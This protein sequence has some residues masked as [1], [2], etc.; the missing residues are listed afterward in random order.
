MSEED[1]F[2]YS[3]PTDMD[4]YANTY[5][6]THV[7]ETDLKRQILMENL[8]SDNLGQVEKLDDFVRDFLKDKCKQKDWEWMSHLKNINRRIP[9]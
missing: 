9:V 1:K 2:R 8:M 4:E 3:L 5:F 7:K 6:A